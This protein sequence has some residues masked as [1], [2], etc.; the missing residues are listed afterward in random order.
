MRL[1][2]LLA[3]VALVCPTLQAGAQNA[4]SRDSTIALFSRDVAKLQRIVDSVAYL[5]S[6]HAAMM[7]REHRHSGRGRRRCL[8]QTA[9][10]HGG[11]VRGEME[12]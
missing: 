10:R 2:R 4:Q 5:S 11:R 6:G 8:G 3:L 12:R 1:I 9:G 7:E